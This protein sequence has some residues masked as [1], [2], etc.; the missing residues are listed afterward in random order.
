MRLPLPAPPPLKRFLHVCADVNFARLD[1]SMH[2]R[3]RGGRGQRGARGE[4]AR[5]VSR[6]YASGTAYSDSRG[7]AKIVLLH[8][9]ESALAPHR[10]AGLWLGP[11]REFGASK[12]SQCERKGRCH[13]ACQ[14]SMTDVETVELGPQPSFSSTTKRVA[15]GEDRVLMV[16]WIY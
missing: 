2:V 6:Y 4:R 13:Y 10:A 8:V 9:A 1:M 3:G 5:Q 12:R 15:F 7:A 11:A 16:R 14:S